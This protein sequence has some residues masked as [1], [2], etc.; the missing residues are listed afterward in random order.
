MIVGFHPLPQNISES[1][2]N[3]TA[4][5]TAIARMLRDIGNA[6]REGL[7]A[8]REYERLK[9]SGISHDLALGASLRASSAESSHR[10]ERCSRA[11]FFSLGPLIGRIG[12]WIG[13]GRGQRALAQLD[14]RLLR[15]IGLTRREEEVRPCPLQ[16]KREWACSCS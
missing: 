11:K 8:H 12:A 5:P 13:R 1:P 7:A 6:F 15:D 16:A 2:D 14:E 9:S 10:Q 4:W 3:A